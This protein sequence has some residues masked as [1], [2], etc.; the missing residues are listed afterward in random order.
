MHDWNSTC[1]V[2]VLKDKGGEKG[3]AGTL[4]GWWKRSGNNSRKGWFDSKTLKHHS[5]HR[6]PVVHL[7]YPDFGLIDRPSSKLHDVVGGDKWLLGKLPSS[8]EDSC[9]VR[10][11]EVDSVLDRKG[12]CGLELLL[13]LSEA[14]YGNAISKKYRC[15]YGA[16]WKICGKGSTLVV[17]LR[18]QPTWLIPWNHRQCKTSTF[19]SEIQALTQ[20]QDAID[21][22]ATTSL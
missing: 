3:S 4:E 2:R 17:S 11:P 15:Q 20:K 9:I 21:S 19:Y 6:I 5:S 1:L 14:T 12:V 8:N 22:E 7:P 13:P 16:I 18:A 10:V